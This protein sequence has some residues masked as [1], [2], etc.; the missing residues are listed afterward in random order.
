LTALVSTDEREV[1]T[2]VLVSPMQTQRTEEQQAVSTQS[3]QTHT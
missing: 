1:Q 2:V 3:M